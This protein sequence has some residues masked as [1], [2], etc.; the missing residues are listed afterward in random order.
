MRT[1]RVAD[2]RK[3]FIKRQN[4]SVSVYSDGNLIRVEDC[5]CYDGNK[6][7]VYVQGY[8]TGNSVINYACKGQA[9]A[10]SRLLNGV[11]RSTLGGWKFEPC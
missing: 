2:G 11:L 5:P 4:G 3:N 6:H 1:A 8:M 10:G 7:F 9:K